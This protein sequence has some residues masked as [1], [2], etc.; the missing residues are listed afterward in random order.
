[1]IKYNIPYTYKNLAYSTAFP[2]QKKYSR[3]NSLIDC[4]FLPNKSTLYKKS[5]FDQKLKLKHV[6]LTSYFVWIKNFYRSK[7]QITTTKAFS[8]FFKFD[9]QYFQKIFSSLNKFSFLEITKA[10]RKL[11]KLKLIK[12]KTYS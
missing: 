4:F 2:Y 11:K 1:M 5:L 3:K 10:I 6:V 12:I 7:K 9:Y 8:R